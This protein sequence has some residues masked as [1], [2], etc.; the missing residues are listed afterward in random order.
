V[1]RFGGHYDE[2]TER[3]IEWILAHYG[4][5]IFRGRSVLDVGGGRGHVAERMLD[6]GAA[7]VEVV[8]GRLGNIR[9]AAS[10]PGLT[11]THANLERGLASAAE[12]YDIV[13]NFGIIY[14]VV[15]WERMLVES[16]AKAREHVF[17]ETEV[18]DSES[19]A[20]RY[21]IEDDAVYDWALAGIGTRP[22][23]FEVDRLLARIPNARPEKVLDAALNAGF[24]RYDWAG[25]LE[26]LTEHGLRRFWTV[27]RTPAADEQAEVD[28]VLAEV[29]HDKTIDTLM[30]ARRTQQLLE[31]G[32]APAAAPEPRRLDTRDLLG[33]LARVQPLHAALEP[34]EE[35]ATLDELDR[36]YRLPGAHASSCTA[37]EGLA[38]YHV[39]AANGLR[40][41]FEI[42]TG[43]G[44][45]TAFIG[46]ALRGSRGTL[47]S[48]DCHVEQPA[49]DDVH[50]AVGEVLASVERQAPPA[51]LAFA[52]EQLGALRLDDVVT[53]SIGISP[54]SVRDAIFG[55]A[56]DFAL[57][58]GGR[59]DDQP[60]RDLEAV[61]AQLDRR[62]AVFF[63]AG[64]D[65]DPAVE[66]AVALAEAALGSA[67]IVLPTRSRLTLVGRDLD[68]AGVA[69]LDELLIRSRA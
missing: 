35:D 40:T 64:N 56:V 13:V 47:V 61:L 22:S 18:I 4:D 16:V 63:F 27:A 36:R 50:A 45:S 41:G 29:H 17:I 24:H 20:T 68:Q 49:R 3:R 39:I 37:E 6:L 26:G 21:V 42:G 65:G 52:S 54:G 59:S 23:E 34:L 38:L 48:M 2:W 12:V 31:R 7:S 69:A 44:Y 60:S 19:E 1:E 53:L 8:E 14:H 62:C 58:D 33:V 28:R 5:D 15:N 25:A 55:R 46:L 51:G 43:F 66:R 9:A 11:F 57:I 10:R 30:I 67:A 32:S